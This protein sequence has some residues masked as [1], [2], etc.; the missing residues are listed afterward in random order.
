MED[1]AKY[2]G[3]TIEKTTYAVE[4]N[5]RVWFS[6]VPNM[7]CEMELTPYE[8]SAYVHLKRIA[9]DSG[10]CWGSSKTMAEK[11]KMSVGQWSKVKKSLAARG[12]IRVDEITEPITINGNCL[13]PQS[14]RPAHVIYILDVWRQNN[15]MFYQQRQSSY[16]ELQSSPHE[17]QSSPDE[18]KKTPIRIHKNIGED[19]DPLDPPNSEIPLT[20]ECILAEIEAAKATQPPKPKSQAKIEQDAMFDVVAYALYGFTPEQQSAMTIDMRSNGGRTAKKLRSLGA[21][22]DHVRVF[23]NKWWK[24]PGHWNWNGKKKRPHPSD[25]IKAW[26]DFTVWYNA[27]K[28]YEAHQAEQEGQRVQPVQPAAPNGTFF[29]MAADPQAAMRELLGV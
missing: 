23:Y 1:R 18:L 10:A 2:N 16:S 4:E 19:A 28:E 7:I 8:L 5:P 17:V 3:E 13:K 20:E 6:M 21:T 22:P 12:L 26:P 15:E 24:I 27:E 25:M 14:G 29:A 9:G 11:T